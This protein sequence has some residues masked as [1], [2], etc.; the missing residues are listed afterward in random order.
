MPQQLRD[1]GWAVVLIALSVV[2][3][4]AVD[5]ALIRGC[6]EGYNLLRRGIHT[7]GVV[8]SLNPPIGEGRPGQAYYRHHIH[9]RTYERF[10]QVNLREYRNVAEGEPVDVVYLEHDPGISRRS[11]ELWRSRV[12]LTGVAL[13]VWNCLWCSALVMVVRRAR[14][15]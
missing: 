2:I 8:T 4:L 7:R 13:L 9:G 10:F 1:T 15:R 11:S 6:M 12:Y 14:A 3:F 5:V